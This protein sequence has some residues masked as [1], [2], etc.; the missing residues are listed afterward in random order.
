MFEIEDYKFI[1]VG[2]FVIFSSEEKIWIVILYD[3][4]ILGIF[5]VI[6]VF[7]GNSGVLSWEKCYKIDNFGKC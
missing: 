3:L 5:S 2:Y 6:F 1:D 4:F 7:I